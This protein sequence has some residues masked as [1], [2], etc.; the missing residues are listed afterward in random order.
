MVHAMESLAGSHKSFST[1]PSCVRSARSRG[2][3][4]EFA[5]VCFYSLKGRSCL[6]FYRHQMEPHL[7]LV[8]PRE[9]APLVSPL[10]T[11]LSLNPKVE[12]DS[13]L[14]LFLECLNDQAVST[15]DPDGI[16]L[17]WNEG[18]R[19][20]KGY[21]A[22]EAIG[23]HFRML[24]SAEDQLQ[25]C[26][27]DNLRL[28]YDNGQFHEEAVRQRKNGESYTAEVSIY[29]L[30]GEG[31]FIGFAKIVRDVSARS[32]ACTTLRRRNAELTVQAKGLT[33][34]NEELEAFSSSV[35][36]DLRGPLGRISGFAGL[37]RRHSGAELDEEG[38]D[39]LNSICAGANKMRQ[40][41]DNLIE[42]ARAGQSELRLDE[43][44]MSAMVRQVASDGDFKNPSCSDHIEIQS[45]VRAQA[46]GSMLELVLKNLIENACKYSDP[47]VSIRFGMDVVDGQC[48][49]Y[50]EDDGIGFEM[51]YAAK[52]FE[53]F[54]RLNAGDKYPGAGI[55][56]ATVRRIVER[57]G[58]KVWAK[59]E[60]GKGSTFF[61][62]LKA[63]RAAA[64]PLKDVA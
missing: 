20:M 35:S 29:P 46:D 52:I 1:I 11:N 8:G 26:P 21:T 55:G 13:K 44:D 6:P 45:G 50:V 56:L 53:P 15:I 49:N 43:V 33:G 51:Q 24:Y 14:H 57:H 18:C 62:T 41:V 42:F 27:E 48:I 40:L 28:A 9:D 47:D 22:E 61:F 34:M 39:Y 10:M 4:L 12:S 60:L 36:H 17:T 54:Q 37:L 38:L 25:G 7:S 23:K 64:T 5:R 19:L 58:G 30:K 2:R 3:A 59:S 31:H 63:D 16:I 32:L